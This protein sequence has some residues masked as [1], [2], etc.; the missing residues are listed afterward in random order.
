MINETKY[1]FGVDVNWTG[2]EDFPT[3]L[4][5]NFGDDYFLV[6]NDRL[7]VGSGNNTMRYL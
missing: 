6:A 4:N 5:M 1:K 7:F 3:E 2:H